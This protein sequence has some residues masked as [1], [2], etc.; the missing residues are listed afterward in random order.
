MTPAKLPPPLLSLLNSYSEIFFIK[1]PYVGAFVLLTTFLYPSVGLMGLISLVSAYMVAHFLGMRKEFLESGFYTYNALL[2]GLSVGYLF[3]FGFLT[4]LVS[5]VGGVLTLFLS[6][7]LSN[8]MSYYLRLPILS[9]PFVVVS[10][11]LYLAVSSYSNLFVDSLY[12][13]VSLPEVVNIPLWLEGFL[14]SLGTVLFLPE[15]LAG[16]VFLGFIFLVSRILFFLAIVGYLAGSVTN[17]LLT[18]SY[19]MA[20]SNIN[21]FNYILIAM[22]LGGVFMVPS[23]RS[24]LIALVG[25]VS[26]TV[27]LSAIETFWSIYQIPVFT[28]PFN[29]VTLTFL[30][31]LRLVSFPTVA[32]Y[33]GDTPEKTLDHYLTYRKRFRGTERGIHLPFSGE[34]VV[35]QGFDGEWTH[36]GIWKFAYDFLIRDEEGKTHRGEGLE[37]EDYYA[38]KKPV[39]SPVRG[40]VVKVVSNLPDNPIGVVD[41]E[42]SWGNLVVIYD[43]RGFYVEISH[44][45]QN[46]VRV[47]EGDWVEVGSFLGLC[48]NS[49][50]SPQPHIHVQVQS[51]E[52]PSSPTLPFSFLSYVKG[53]EFFS[54]DLPKAG[55][56]VSNLLPDKSVANRLSFYL[57]NEFIYEVYEGNEKRRELTLK[58][59][60]E[61]DGTF[62]FDSGR[63]RLYFW[64][65]V[66][67]FYFL[68]TEGKDPYLNM[69]FSA[70][71]RA[72]ISSKRGLVWKDH[73]PISSSHRGVV[74]DALLFL[75]SFKSDVAE[76][77]FT[78][79]VE[80][81]GEFSGEVDMGSFGRVKTRVTLDE[82]LGFREIRF[83]DTK[84]LLK[85][86]KFGG[87]S[88]A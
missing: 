35:W 5:A 36:K 2:V 33:I 88:D 38:F 58:V 80:G 26:S 45:A 41:R 22:A 57:D 24:Y 21:N 83:G 67:T 30:Y 15:A 46:S 16:L 4:A 62:Y 7:F 52:D 27:V 74:R 73:I 68:R 60:M 34:W 63:G 49:G 77:K 51:G 86:T 13:K 69:I 54:N 18:G 53:E 66:G 47:K 37:L 11:I 81:E 25:A 6:V 84:L 23:P 31:T 82:V 56:K 75:A 9:L 44:L 64:K 48:G 14:K 19:T 72:P 65:D 3:K 55:D 10:S 8:T 43:Y 79:R 28:L 85:E 1:D 71:P 61:T 29:F 40:R 78:G 50:Y 87:E 32:H 42:N 17:S 59:K 76:A 20:F 70:L 39:L 12:P